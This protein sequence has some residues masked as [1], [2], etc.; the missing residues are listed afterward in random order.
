MLMI[1]N[2]ICKIHRTNSKILIVVQIPFHLLV[3][4][5]CRFLSSNYI[6]LISTKN[7][8]SSTSKCF[9]AEK[10]SYLYRRKKIQ[11]SRNF[12]ILFKK[13]SRYFI[14]KAYSKSPSLTNEETVGVIVVIRRRTDFLLGS[15]SVCAVLVA[16]KFFGRQAPPNRRCLL[17]FIIQK[18]GNYKLPLTCFNRHN[19][20]S[21]F[22]TK[23]PNK[24]FAE[25]LFNLS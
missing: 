22:A 20:S 18:Y 7:P 19:T 14:Q 25:V 4:P 2:I 15:E 24:N 3:L 23:P 21:L 17:S 9:K 6:L 11:S 12:K 5:D 10:A 13:L 8:F 1:E 16:Q